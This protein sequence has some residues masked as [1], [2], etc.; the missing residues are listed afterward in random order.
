M[1]FIRPR[2][3][4]EV[5]AFGGEGEASEI[6]RGPHC[7]F[8]CLGPDARRGDGKL[9]HQRFHFFEGG[10][11]V[12]TFKGALVHARLDTFAD[13]RETGEANPGWTWS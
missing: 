11:A 2:G 8:S 5:R 10:G 1:V 13:S 12:H 3:V 4:V 7:W 9:L 6:S